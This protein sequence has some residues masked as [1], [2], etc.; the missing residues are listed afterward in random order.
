MVIKAGDTQRGMVD[1]AV[2]SL[3]Q[4]HANIIG[5]VLTGVE[6]FIPE[7]IYRYL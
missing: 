1:R 6:Y 5:H 2:E 7:Y 3:V 4:A